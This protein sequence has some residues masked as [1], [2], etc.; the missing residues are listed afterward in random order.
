MLMLPLLFLIL[1]T[2]IC[3]GLVF[4]YSF[5]RRESILS[6]ARRCEK[7]G[8][9][10]EAIKLYRVICEHIHDDKFNDGHLKIARTRLQ[11]LGM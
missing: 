4:R 9:K 5:R 3:P 10:N 2:I 1:T 6:R 7:K 8:R 11:A